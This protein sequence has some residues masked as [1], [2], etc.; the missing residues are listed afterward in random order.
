M[1]PRMMTRCAS[2]ATAAPR[3]G[4]TSGRTGNEVNDGVDGFPDFS[5]IIAQ[6]LHNLLPTILAQEGNKG[7]NQGNNRNQNG[8]AVN[9]NIQGDVMNVFVNNGQRDCSYME[10]LACNPK[11]YDGKGGVI[12]Y[13]HWIEKIESVQDMSRCGDDQKMK[14]TTGSFVGKALT[15]GNSQIYTRGRET[16]VGMALEDFK[17]L[18]REEFCPINEMQ[19]LETKFWNHAMVGTGHALYTNKFHE[20]VRLV[21]HLVTPKTEGLRGTSMA[22]LHKSEGWW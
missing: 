12:V 20:L 9:D 17:T 7:N 21:P 8:D 13:T 16:A 11:E 15:W 4:R 2:R 10:F 19:N 18:M 6:Q 5:T 14:Y 22:L 1:S 3:G